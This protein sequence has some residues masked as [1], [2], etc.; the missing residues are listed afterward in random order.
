MTAPDPEGN[1]VYA[2]VLLLEEALADDDRDRVLALHAGEDL[3]IHV[4]V[5]VDTHH[6][7]VVEALDEI[8]LGR[9]REATHDP[10][11]LPAAT[12]RARAQEALDA[13]VRAL[14]ST[15]VDADGSLSDDDPVD[16]TI[17]TATRLD[18]DEVIVVTAPHLL[19][20]TFR[21]DWGSRIRSGLERPV[22]HFV[23]GTDRVY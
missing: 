8:A 18:T 12:A 1:R 3:R 13:S 9:L 4:L 22:L 20:T 10:G 23:A 6:S 17:S 5:P 14:A 15:G 19:E 21:R 2:I 11:D 16:A 7:K